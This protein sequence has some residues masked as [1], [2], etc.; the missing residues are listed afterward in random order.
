MFVVGELNGAVDD[1]T[2]YLQN[3]NLA[4]WCEAFAVMRTCLER[5]LVFRRWWQ[6][7]FI[8][9]CSGTGRWSLVSRANLFFVSCGVG[10]R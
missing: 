4:G 1:M 10:G 6:G 8:I 3:E 9:C 5:M 2:W 7:R